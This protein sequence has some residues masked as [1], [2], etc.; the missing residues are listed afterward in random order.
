MNTAPVL[1][2]PA[3]WRCVDFLSDVHLHM[4]DAD[5][6][7]AWQRYMA[8][9]EADALFILGDLFE[10]WVGDD[11]LDHP[12]QGHFWQA[13]ARVLHHTSQRM[14]V[15]FMV[16]NRDFLVGER[17]LDVAGLTGLSDPTVLTWAGQ[18]WLLSHGDALCTAD[19]AYQAF[20]AQVRQSTWT[21]T[22]LAKPLDERLALARGMRQASEERKH[23][24]DE[25]ADV[26][27]P[28]ALAA[29]LAN[30]CQ[31]LI[32]GHTHQPAVH[33]LDAL[34][35][36]HV[37]SDWDARAT[38]PRLQVLRAERGQAPQPVDTHNL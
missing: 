2:A 15:Y 32:H 6:F 5:T 10:V 14:P 30:H 12:E 27:T 17:L 3:H 20:R 16:G 25:W 1:Q 13:C 4:D 29:T 31:R 35:H 37:L 8:H 7:A 33:Q 11:V 24:Q 36:R 19:V 18:R 22:F 9:T 34:H 26:D 28:T 21:Q 23:T 38:P